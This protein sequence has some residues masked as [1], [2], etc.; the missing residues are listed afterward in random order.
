MTMII[1]KI[2]LSGWTKLMLNTG[3][4]VFTMR[5]RKIKISHVKCGGPAVIEIFGEEPFAPE[6]KSEN[7]LIQR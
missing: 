6:S 2:W 3:M 1:K 7:A 4:S 5:L